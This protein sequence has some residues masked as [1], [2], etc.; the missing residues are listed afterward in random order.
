MSR[1]STAWASTLEHIRRSNVRGD[2]TKTII[3]LTL[4]GRK[5]YFRHENFEQQPEAKIRHLG[6]PENAE[7]EVGPQITTEH[8]PN[9]PEA[10]A[11][12]RLLESHSKHRIE[13]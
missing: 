5:N 11:Q 8:G 3:K 12:K 7:A 9:Q 1:S 4:N 10:V 2:K 13:Q 6:E